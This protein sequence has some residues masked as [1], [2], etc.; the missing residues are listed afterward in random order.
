ML[1]YKEPLECYKKLAQDLQDIA[2]G[3]KP[4]ENA[5]AENTGSYRQ[6]RQPPS[7][8]QTTV[9]DNRSTWKAWQQSK[10]NNGN[11]TLT[12]A[13]LPGLLPSGLATCFLT[14]PLPTLSG[15][16]AA[17][18]AGTAASSSAA[19]IASGCPTAAAS[20]S[21]GA[22]ARTSGGGSA[23][24]FSAGPTLLTS[25]ARF[26]PWLVTP[27]LSSSTPPKELPSTRNRVGISLLCSHAA[28][29]EQRADGRL[30]QGPAHEQAVVQEQLH[31]SD[32]FV[33][34]HAGVV[35]LRRADVPVQLLGPRPC[36]QIRI[37]V[38]K[39]AV[40]HPVGVYVWHHQPI[41]ALC[42][43]LQYVAC[44]EVHP[45]GVLVEVVQLHVQVVLCLNSYWHQPEADAV[46]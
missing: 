14:L 45:H 8:P 43:S 7:E 35:L 4:V 32:V 46:A 36:R 41:A 40:R 9:N 39:D 16:T 15:T 31:L 28:V 12:P 2:S 21:T 30:Q 19:G 17:A 3:T 13:A 22:G 20:A 34:L 10:K 27:S 37:I 29:H 5:G 11:E 1:K 42:L 44:P 23:K 25:R 18:A 33:G 38:D 26:M 24:R 6:H